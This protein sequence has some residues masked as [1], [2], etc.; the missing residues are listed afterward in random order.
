MLRHGGAS[1]VERVDSASQQNHTPAQWLMSRPPPPDEFFGLVRLRTALQDIAG[2]GSTVNG[3]KLGRFVARHE[4]RI[5]DGRR[6]VR[7]GERRAG[8]LWCVETVAT[9][10]GFAGFYQPPTRECPAREH[11]SN[12][13]SYIETAGKNPQKAQN[14]QALAEVEI[15]L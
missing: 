15:D 2:E 11:D 12:N 5:E 14:P 13:D 3:R 10:A 7:G 8:A 6:F 9:G 4:G 1:S